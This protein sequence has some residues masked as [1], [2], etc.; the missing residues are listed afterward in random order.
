MSLQ[1]QIRNDMV[2]AMKARETEKLS[3]LRVVTGEFGRIGKDLTDEEV[4]KVLRKMAENANDLGNDEEFKILDS[5]LPKMLEPK[6]IKVI[7]KNI[8]EFN[9]F[10]SIK[11]M[12]QVMGK[13]K[14][15][16][17]SQ[18]IDMRAASILVRE[19]LTK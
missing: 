9:N 17:E 16:K 18:L 12:G 11:E 4:L 5:Y 13:I 6:E 10:T 2:N 15:N 8:I 14:Q 19:L 3:I 7:V 1:K